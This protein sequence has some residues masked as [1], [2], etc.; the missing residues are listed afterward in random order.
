MIYTYICIVYKY[1]FIDSYTI[2]LSRDMYIKNENEYTRNKNIQIHTQKYQAGGWGGEKSQSVNI[3]VMCIHTR[4]IVYVCM[5]MKVFK[6]KIKKKHEYELSIDHVWLCSL[7][8]LCLYCKNCIV[9]RVDISGEYFY[10]I[11]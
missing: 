4:C 7:L 11:F 9:D 10:F 3:C 2:I 8:K 5:Y 6:I 1:P